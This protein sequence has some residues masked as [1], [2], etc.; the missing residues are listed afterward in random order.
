MSAESPGARDRISSLRTAFKY[1]RWQRPFWAGLLTML[2]GLPIGYLPYAN[3]TLG[4][5]TVRMSTTTG[6]GSLII[7]VLLVVLGLTMWFQPIVRVFAGVATI[8]LGLVSIPVANFGGFVVGFL[9]ALFGGGMSVAWA[10]GEASTEQPAKDAGPAPTE[11]ADG[12]DGA[13]GGEPE[14][15]VAGAAPDQESRDGRHRAG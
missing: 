11:G 3:V 9:L 5:L 1:W 12:V 14:P 10:P 7:G 2:G 8:L 15:A 6:S 13:G 4:Q